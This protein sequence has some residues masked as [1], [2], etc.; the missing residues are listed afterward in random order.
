[1]RESSSLSEAF[2]KGGAGAEALAQKVVET[3]ARNPDVHVQPVYAFE[4]SVEEKIAKIAVKI[5]GAA[6]VKF[7]L[8]RA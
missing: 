4:D 2:T 8:Q 3:I 7:C 6:G 5:Y 1:M